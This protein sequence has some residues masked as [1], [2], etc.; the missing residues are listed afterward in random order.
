VVLEFNKFTMGNYI[1]THIEI[2]LCLN[3]I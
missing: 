1:V 2:Y 3:Y